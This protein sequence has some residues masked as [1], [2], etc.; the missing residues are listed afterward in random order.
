MLCK[1]KERLSFKKNW[2]NSKSSVILKAFKALSKTHLNIDKGWKTE[3]NISSSYIFF[4][5]ILWIVRLK[6]FSYSLV[7]IFFEKKKKLLQLF[8]KYLKKNKNWL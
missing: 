8:L 1:R 6:S 2:Y 4:C 5:F 7:N 3:P